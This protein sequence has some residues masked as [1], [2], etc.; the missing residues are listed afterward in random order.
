MIVTISRVQV[1]VDRAAGREV[2][3]DRIYAKE[4]VNEEIPNIR[5]SR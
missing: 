2:R 5:F 1:N 3:G 4:F